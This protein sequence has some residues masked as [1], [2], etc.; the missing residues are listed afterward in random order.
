VIFGELIPT[1]SS[2]QLGTFIMILVAVLGGYMRL[3]KFEDY[4]RGQGERREI[5]P[6]P[7]EVRKAADYIL[8]E[9]CEKVHARMEAE[10]AQHSASRKSIYDRIEEMDGRAAAR[11]EVLRKEVKE[12]IRGVHDRVNDVLHAVGRLEGKNE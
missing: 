1:V 7:L 8:R 2:I 12:D 6:Q 11:T 9:Q 10:F 4:M 3:R 5:S